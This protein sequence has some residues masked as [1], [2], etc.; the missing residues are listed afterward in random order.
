MSIIRSHICVC[1][2]TYK[3]QKLLENLLKILQNQRTDGIFTY[4][5]LV[6]DNDHEQSA[7]NV[8]DSCKKKSVIPIDYYIEPEKSIAL[9]RNKAVRNANGDFIAFIDD[10]EFPVND[11]LYNLH[12]TCCQ[13][14][15]DSVLGPV[16]P[17]FETDPPDW[18]VKGKL[19][20][21][22]SYKTGTVLKWYNTRTGNVLLRKCIFEESSNLFRPEF[23]HS[24][25][26]DFFKRIAEKGHIVIWC[27]EAK[28]YEIQTSDRFKVVYFIRRALLRGN[29]S[30]RL[31][32]NKLLIIIKSTIAFLIYTLSLPFM[33]IISQHL[34]IKYLIKD[35]DHIGK[36]IASCKIDIQRYL[37]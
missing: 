15:A 21:R 32:S 1:I 11:W 12:K 18:I 10:D 16:K 22:P 7:R 14:N 3:R 28:V 13:Y 26:Q 33:M 29:V 24:E 25:D 19:F 17:K 27:D 23:R 30:V 34:F 35:F 36:L 37:A 20:E 5:V 4:S 2:C 8:V 6:V 31:Q 9:A